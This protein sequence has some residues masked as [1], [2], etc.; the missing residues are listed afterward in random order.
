[1][2]TL[3][4][5]AEKNAN[6]ATKAGDL[7]V[8]GGGV[9]KSAKRRAAKQ[10]SKA[11]AATVASNVQDTVAKAVAEALNQ[12]FAGKGFGK[13]QYGGSGSYGGPYGGK[14]KGGGKFNGTCNNCGAIGHKA[15]ECRRPPRST[16]YGKGS[17]KWYVKG[18]DGGNHFPATGKW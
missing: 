14:G 17:G 2:P 6:I 1:M 8:P 18:R 5:L 11:M 3:A 16:P 10:Q 4:L 13:Q 7:A 12:A 15:Y 9:S